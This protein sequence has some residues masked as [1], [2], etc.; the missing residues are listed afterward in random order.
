LLPA[1]RREPPQEFPVING[2]MGNSLATVRAITWHSPKAAES[3][4]PV[5]SV[6]AIGEYYTA[7]QRWARSLT[8]AMKYAPFVLVMRCSRL[9][10]RVSEMAIQTSPSGYSRMTFR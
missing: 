6:D 5:K 8:V 1:S 7:A 9:A 2:T 3:L 4:K 10:W